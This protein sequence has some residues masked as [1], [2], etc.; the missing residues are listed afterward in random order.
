M[1]STL[2]DG[3]GIDD[4]DV[5]ITDSSGER[6]VALDLNGADSGLQTLGQLVDAIN[7]KANANGTGVVARIN[8][9]KT[10]IEL[11][12]TAGGTNKL[13]VKD[14]GGGSSAVDLNIA[15][16]AKLVDGKQIIDGSGLFDLNDGRNSR[17]ASLA[18]R[19]NRADVGVTAQ[20]QFDGTGY[21]LTVAADATGEAN[22][23]TLDAAA[24]GFAFEQ[25][26]QAQDGLLL[27]GNAG[28]NGG[29]LLLSSA[30]DTFKNAAPGVD[31]VVNEATGATVTVTVAQKS[32]DVTDAVK[33]I[34]DSYNSLRSDLSKLTA[35]DAANSTTGLLF[36]TSEA[37]QVDS[38]LSRA[39]T[40]RFL[41][42]GRFQSL[43]ELGV[44][45]EKD[46]TLSLDKTK[47]GTA[48][49]ADS[50]AVEKFF[51]DASA[52]FVK[53][54]GDVV[55]RTA[56]AKTSLLASRSASITAT[57]EVNQKRITAYG[58][59]LDKQK[60]QMLLRFNQLELIISK[61]RQSQT[62]IGSIKTLTSTSTSTS[63]A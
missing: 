20:V 57:L 38:R 19:I 8:A 41:G 46:G 16:E 26:S 37:L 45:V 44:S 48:F 55:D 53:K 27:S 47:L 63:T 4:G 42:V 5:L 28:S 31:V 60:E 9:K 59:Q 3:K 21:R 15:G 23:F 29:S 43:A 40:D 2:H 62:A 58:E 1:L 35:F 12:D 17:L 11:E 34:V 36:G 24:A 49:E 22:Q 30:N 54:L 56:G 39:L 61:L 14:L 18:A 52:G 32:S 33:G 50:Q 7:A 51:A 10:G 13:T 25:T 6:S